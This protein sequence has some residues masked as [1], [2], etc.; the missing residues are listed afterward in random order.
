MLPITLSAWSIC[1]NLNRFQ[2]Y[3]SESA[4]FICETE[5]SFAKLVKTNR[6]TVSLS[7]P[8]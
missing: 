6:I 7:K 4:Q 2:I 8:E 1:R 3:F 5:T